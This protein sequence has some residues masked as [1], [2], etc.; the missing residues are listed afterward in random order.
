MDEHAEAHR[1]PVRTHFG[2]I[3]HIISI[4]GVFVCLFCQV[5]AMEPQTHDLPASVSLLQGLQAWAIAFL[6]LMMRSQI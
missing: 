4:Y 1:R 6:I 5:S 2:D 3:G